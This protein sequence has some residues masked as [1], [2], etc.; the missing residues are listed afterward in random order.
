MRGVELDCCAGSLKRTFPPSRGRVFFVTAAAAAAVATASVTKEATAALVTRL[1][2][3]L[4]LEQQLQFVPHLI[5]RLLVLVIERVIGI[6][7]AQKIFWPSS[8]AAHQARPGLLVFVVSA[9]RVEPSLSSRSSGIARQW[10][11]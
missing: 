2:G 8:D 10:R 7:G 9:E 6:D 4:S 5:L 11:M 1:L 3:L